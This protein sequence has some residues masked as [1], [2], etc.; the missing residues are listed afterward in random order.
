MPNSAS[1]PPQKLE[2]PTLPAARPPPPLKRPRAR[3]AAKPK[4]TKIPPPVA[5]VPD[6]SRISSAT[7]HFSVLQGAALLGGSHGNPVPPGLLSISAPLPQAALGPTPGSPPPLPIRV[8]T[9]VAVVTPPVLNSGAAVLLPT[10]PLPPPLPSSPTGRPVAAAAQLSRV[11]FAAPSPAAAAARP[12]VAGPAAAAS[13]VLPLPPPRVIQ[14]APKHKTNPLAGGRTPP[15]SST[16]TRTGNTGT[17]P[18]FVFLKLNLKAFYGNDEKKKNFLFRCFVSSASR[19][20]AQASQVHTTAV[21][22]LV[23]K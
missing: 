18:C 3:A 16:P 22:T 1:N 13:T 9:S 5:T 20:A 21:D 12:R 10:A 7:P 11:Q 8:P 6:S 17:L 23:Y 2:S 4:R 19:S 15:V 14:Y